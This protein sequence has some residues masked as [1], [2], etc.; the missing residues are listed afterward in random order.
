[1]KKI[2]LALMLLLTS[3]SFAAKTVIFSAETEN[4][5]I[6]EIAKDDKEE[7]YFYYSYG[8]KGKP[9]IT[10]KCYEDETLFKGFG[11][12]GGNAYVYTI[13]FV[14]PQA[15]K[16]SYQIKKAISQKTFYILEVFKEEEMISSID[17]DPKTV[18][19]EFPYEVISSEGDI[20]DFMSF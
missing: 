18:K 16:Y 11:N 17:I 3:F 15:K 13:R 5:K 1:M 2:I 7:S 9:E 6:V 14:N 20:D 12:F 8:K 4:G 19:G 10:L